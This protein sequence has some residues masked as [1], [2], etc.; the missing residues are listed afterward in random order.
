MQTQMFSLM[1]FIKEMN[2]YNLMQLKWILRRF[3]AVHKQYINNCLVYT[4]QVNSAFGAGWL[5]SSEVII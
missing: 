1:S 3:T 4:T 2:N 5:A